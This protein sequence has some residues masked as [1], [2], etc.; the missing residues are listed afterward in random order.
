MT[1]VAIAVATPVVLFATILAVAYWRVKLP[2]DHVAT[3]STLV[4]ATDAADHCDESNAMAAFVGDQDRTNVHLADVA[5]VLIDAV[6]SAED[7]SFYSH[8]GVDPVGMVRALWSDVRGNATQGGSTITQ[9][10]VKNAYLANEASARSGVSGVTRKVK[11]AVLAVKVEQQLSKDQILER[12][13]NTIYFGRGAYGIGAAARA[14]FGRAPHDLDLPQA[15]FLAGLIRSPGTADPAIDPT[16]ATK[17]RLSVLNA[18]VAAGKITAEQRDAASAQPWVVA[19]LPDGS[20]GTVL[21]P[22]AR[23][24]IEVR[25]G[26]GTGIE[27]VLDVVHQQLS[28]AGYTD[29]EIYGGGLRVYTTIDLA[30]QAQAWNAVSSVLDQPED[31]SAALVAVDKDGAVR[32]MVGGRDHATDKVNLAMGAEGGGSGRQ[33]GSAFKPFV[34]AAAVHDGMPLTKTFDAPSVITI[35]KADDG[36]DWVVR[37][38]EPS[39]GSLDLTSATALSSNTVFAQLIVQ[40]GPDKAAAMAKQMGI[41][42]DVPALPSITLGTAEVSPYQMADAYSTL[43]RGGEHVTPTVVTHVVRADG[44][45]KTFDQARSRVLSDDEAATVTSALRQVID[46]GTG[47]G[48]NPGVPAAGKTGTTEDHNDAWFVGYLPDGFTAA[49]WMG[50]E[51]P[52]GQPART[53]EQLRG[54]GPAFGGGIPASIWKAF[55]VEAAK[56]RDVGTFRDPP[57]PSIASGDVLSPLDA[58]SSPATSSST[59]TPGPA[60]TANDGTSGNG[61]GYGNGNGPPTTSP[62]TTA[63][64]STTTPPTTSP[65][66]TA[67]NSVPVTTIPP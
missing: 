36:H 51:N 5:P 17:R 3:Q 61:K 32:A 20:D 56:G 35:P 57:P 6:L 2:P 33:A 58:E 50:Y 10:Y 24:S 59:T 42:A 53:M 31:P 16:T 54:A 18:M 62:P 39:S 27:Y 13:L 48:A 63:P 4:C 49:V 23:S 34:L 28:A 65:P 46:R 30:A 55:M 64:P 9:Q 26:A 22:S 8:S 66:T 7:R 25:R 67:P 44:S 60:T 19:A 14:Y 47:T 11:E 12:Y 52:P 40:L 41:T 21:P 43:A 29:A 37:N 15:A 38:A 45:T 1:F